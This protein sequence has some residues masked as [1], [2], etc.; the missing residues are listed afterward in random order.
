[1]PRILAMRG[2]L[3]LVITATIAFAIILHAGA[4]FAWGASAYRIV[5]LTAAQSLPAEMPQFLR[6]AEAARQVSEVSRQPDWSNAGNSAAANFVLVGD[7]LRIARGPLLS[8]LPPN[9]AA[10]DTAL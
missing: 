1:M 3:L 6:T 2:N 9:R 10:Y 8:A 7:D 5:S 4:A